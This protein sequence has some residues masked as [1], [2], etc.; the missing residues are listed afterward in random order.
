MV[1]PILKFGILGT[2]TLTK[3]MAKRIANRFKRNVK[4]RRYCHIFMQN[5]DDSIYYMKYVSFKHMPRRF[6]MGEIPRPKKITEQEAL[7]TGAVFFSEAIVLMVAIIFI[8]YEYNKSGR[9]ETKLYTRIDQLEQDVV[10]LKN[11]QIVV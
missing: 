2:K 9:K 8:I 11:K 1:L 6:D 4:F 7:E 10:E 3:F 5:Y